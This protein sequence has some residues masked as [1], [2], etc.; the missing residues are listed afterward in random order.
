MI[1]ILAIL[2][3]MSVVIPQIVKTIQSKSTDGLS[4]AM[5]IQLAL[6]CI[7]MIIKAYTTGVYFFIISY[8]VTL[9]SALTMIYLIRK[10]TCNI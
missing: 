8:S 10:Y 9:V 2:L 4:V 1:E 6:A 3:S 7:L 5:Y